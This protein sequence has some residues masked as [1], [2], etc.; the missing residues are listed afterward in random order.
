MSL[1]RQVLKECNCDRVL[2]RDSSRRSDAVYSCIASLWA[3]HD[4]RTHSPHVMNLKM[5]AVNQFT[6]VLDLSMS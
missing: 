2:V 1:D 3:L 6:Y 4:C 5:K